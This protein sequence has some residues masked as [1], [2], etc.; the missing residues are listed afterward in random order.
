MGR[1]PIERCVGDPERFATEVWSRRWHRYPEADAAAFADVLSLAAVDDLLAAGGLR[2][3]ALRVVRDGKTLPRSRFSRS[4]TTG[5]RRVGD[6]VDAD[7]VLRAFAD[8]ATVVLQA[9]HRFHAPVQ[10]FCD[11][12]EAFFGHPLQANAYLT[13]AKSRGL[14]VHHDTHDVLVLQLHGTKEWLLYDPVVPDPVSAHP[15]SPRHPKPGPVVET[16]SLAAGDCLYLPR[17][18]P[19]QALGLDGAS[20]HLTLGVRSPTWL[21]VVGRVMKGVAEI[22]ELRRALPLQYATHPGALEAELPAILERVA[23]WLRARDTAAL[24]A[25]EVR[26][27]RSLRRPSDRGRLRAIAEPG[28]ID[29]ETSLMR[30]DEV[31]WR[32]ESRG[33]SVVLHAGQ[34]ALRFP[35]RIRPAL[36]ALVSAP[37]LKA[38]EL[39]DHLDEPGRLVLVRRLAR[40]G[41]LRR[42]AR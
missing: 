6:A 34:A 2:H 17:G 3:P 16:V 28:A 24:A 42:E 20:L 22:P 12:L 26:R 39:A 38:S 21:D 31:P 41:L 40:E 10:A 1:A 25:S 27:A 36:E 23:Q 8:G 7:A 14:S 35:L 18:V 33:D 4:H 37:A 30:A 32:L 9:L 13:P 29:D 5:G 19:H 11:G 15:K